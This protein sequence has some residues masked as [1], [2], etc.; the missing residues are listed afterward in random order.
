MTNS[1]Y[2]VPIWKCKLGRR[3]YWFE[4]EAQLDE[5]IVKKRKEGL[6]PRDAGYITLDRRK[7]KLVEFLNGMQNERA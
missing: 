2:E 3:T 4:R 6:H 1:D 5:F 7:N